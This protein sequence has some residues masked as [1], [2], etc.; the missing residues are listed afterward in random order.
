[1][2]IELQSV[3]TR[4]HQLTTSRAWAVAA[5]FQRV[6]YWL[7]S[8]PADQRRQKACE[9]A[10][11]VL[12]KIGLYRLAAGGWRQAEQVKRLLLRQSAAPVAATVQS[13][14]GILADDNP[15][16]YD[17][18]CLP[19]ILW[20]SRF[21][22]PQQ[23]IDQFAR[24]GHRVFYASVGFCGGKSVQLSRQRPGVYEMMLPGTPGVNVYSE[25][26]ADTDVALMADAIDRLRVE[27]RLASAVV[28]VQLPFWTALAERLRER[29]GW[30]I[31]Y[32][33]MD[34]HAGF[35]T[36]CES[37][38]RAEERTLAGSDLV[39][40]TADLLDT[41]ARAKARRTT[42][43]RNACDYEHFATVSSTAA[44]NRNYAIPIAGGQRRTEG[45][46][47]QGGSPG[48]ARSRLFLRLNDN[49]TRDKQATIGFYGAIAEWFDADLV[50]RL[51]ELR[52]GWKFE[53]IGSTVT[54]DVSRLQELSNVTLLGEKPYSELPR[55]VAGWDCFI[56]PFKRIPLTEAT[57]PVKAYEMLAT[58]KP[59]VAVNLPELR[60]MARDG[61]LSIAD[62]AGHSPRRSTGLWA[63][64]TT[65]AASVARRSPRKTPGATATAPSM[66]PSANCSR[67]RRSLS[68]PTTIWR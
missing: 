23:L 27:G 49:A 13:A 58:G 50:A 51:A 41:K 21:Q 12:R 40:V 55:L 52:P 2:E 42:L 56:I 28:V 36:N 22:R 32:D 1:M 44:E 46:A 8:G 26:P 38:L 54:G 62:D 64:T 18:I 10:K 7:W 31:V 53:L 67:R 34:D 45:A 19:V 3:H 11:R 29:F 4:L 33:C 48:Y 68:S 47:T 9:F 14:A 17:V 39:V 16:R 61:L 20:N 35:S 24:R 59:V 65:A 63:K 57:N 25:L 15:Q 37:M 66:R 6:R 5:F 43:I 30:P 60:P